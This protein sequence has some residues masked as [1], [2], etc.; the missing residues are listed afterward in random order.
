MNK[1]LSAN[2]ARLKKDTAL[3]L[4]IIF[5]FVMGVLLPFMN[6]RTMTAY[7]I[8]IYIDGNNFSSFLQSVYRHRIQRRD[9]PQQT[10]HRA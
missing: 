1:L 8:P 5:M 4:C 9:H 3:K 6:Y 2:F 7:D 10:D